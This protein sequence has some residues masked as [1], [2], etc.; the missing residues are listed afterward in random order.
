M[1]GKLSLK[2]FELGRRHWAG[3]DWALVVAEVQQ[4][5]SARMLLTGALSQGL[6]G[7]TLRWME[8]FTQEQRLGADRL[9][10]SLSEVTSQVASEILHEDRAARERLGGVCCPRSAHQHS[11]V[12]HGNDANARLKL[13]SRSI[14]KAPPGDEHLASLEEIVEFRCH[15]LHT[16]TSWIAVTNWKA[17]ASESDCV[18]E[19]RT[20]QKSGAAARRHLAAS[21]RR[22][23]ASPSQVRLLAHALVPGRRGRVC[24]PRGQQP[25]L[26]E[27]EFKLW[28]LAW[29][30]RGLVEL[31]RRGA[32]QY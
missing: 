22:E 11:K 13:M 17:E 15:H 10:E 24:L 4:R 9:L 25:S 27:L 21:G 31:G 19:D 16:A 20:N 23:G 14:L 5:F 12:A 7:L 18:A 6:K 2:E 3:A 28:G 26:D 8:A 32:P 1:A 30:G 29:L